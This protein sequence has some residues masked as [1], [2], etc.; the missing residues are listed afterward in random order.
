MPR[1]A[2]VPC[3]GFGSLTAFRSWEFRS[4]VGAKGGALRSPCTIPAF[5][6]RASARPTLTRSA[7]KTCCAAI[8]TRRISPESTI[9]TSNLQSSIRVC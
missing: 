9:V 8:H 1:L 6:T 7:S 3:P 4:Q 5:G 2:S